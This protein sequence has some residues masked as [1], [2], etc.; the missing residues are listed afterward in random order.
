MNDDD[1]SA[2]IASAA[3]PKTSPPGLTS[4]QARALLDERG[5]NTVPEQRPSV[6]SR[7]VCTREHAW[8]SRPSRW[9][10]GATTANFAVALTLTLTG[11]LM[12][13]L[14]GVVAAIVT[15]TLCVAALIAD[16]LKIPT[17]KALGLHRLWRV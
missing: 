5:P 9:L 10:M 8:T 13:P 4:V 6:L 17:F 16:Y 3:G 11:T 1:E 7:I 12:S 15:G 14:P 2:G